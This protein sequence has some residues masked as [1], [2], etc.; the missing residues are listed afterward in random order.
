MV[1]IHALWSSSLVSSAASS[2]SKTAL[3]SF[4]SIALVFFFFFV[5]MGREEEGGSGSRGREEEGANGCRG[6]RFTADSSLDLRV[7]RTRKG[8][9]AHTS[10]QKGKPNLYRAFDAGSVHSSY[11][12]RGSTNHLAILMQTWFAFLK[13]V[14]LSKRGP[15]LLCSF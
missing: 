9:R 15:R 3:S 8:S 4:F 13:N 5:Q 6:R 12:T 10:D 11:C 1:T 14:S 2:P 7:H